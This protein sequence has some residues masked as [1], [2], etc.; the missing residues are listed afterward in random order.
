VRVPEVTIDRSEPYSVGSALKVEA[1]LPAGVLRNYEIVID[2]QDRTF[3]VAVPGRLR[4]HGV[5]VPFHINGETG[6]IAIDA[7]IAG[8]SY[9]ITIDSG[10]AYTW[11]RQS[12]VKDWLP[13]HPGW[14]RGVGAVGMSNMRMADDGAESQGIL[15]RLPEI[16]LGA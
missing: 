16:R 13:A 10:S 15:L 8:R 7:S 2:Y 14:E 1:L 6:L 5:P 12:T 3:T 4:P 9:P 11:F